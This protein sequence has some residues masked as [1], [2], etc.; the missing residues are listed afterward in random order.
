MKRGPD[1][2]GEG[3]AACKVGGVV[4]AHGKGNIPDPVSCNIGFCL[5][6]VCR[7]LCG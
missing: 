4:Y 1:P 5:D 2:G 3:K 6:G 7:N